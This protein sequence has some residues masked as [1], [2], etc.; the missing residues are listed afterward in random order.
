M[1]FGLNLARL[2]GEG[3]GGYIDRGQDGR[4]D[5]GLGGGARWGG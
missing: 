5:G 3:A 2:K 4:L 1:R